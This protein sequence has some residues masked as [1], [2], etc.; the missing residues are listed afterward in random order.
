MIPII[1]SHED[2]HGLS[3]LS[4]IN[5]FFGFD[6]KTKSVKDEGGGR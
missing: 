6:S 4:K 5:N 1:L 2:K 3:T